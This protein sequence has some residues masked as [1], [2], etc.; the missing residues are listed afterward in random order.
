[1]GG[2]VPQGQRGWRSEGYCERLSDFCIL[3]HIEWIWVR[4][5]AFRGFRHCTFILTFGGMPVDYL[6]TVTLTTYFETIHLESQKHQVLKCWIMQRR[7]AREAKLTPSSRA[8]A[9]LLLWMTSVGEAR[10]AFLPSLCDRQSWLPAVVR[11]ETVSETECIPDIQV[12][13]EES[14]CLS[15]LSE[16]LKPLTIEM[17]PSTNHPKNRTHPPRLISHGAWVWGH[18]FPKR[19][20]TGK[21]HFVV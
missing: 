3:V 18:T 10:I 20:R 13:P 15:R 12:T 21:G 1:M 14:L 7:L 11:R 8:S 4:A 2:S 19:Q 6:I 5:C 9:L 17:T 16:F